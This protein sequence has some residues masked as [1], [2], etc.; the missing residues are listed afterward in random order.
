MSISKYFIDDKYLKSVLSNYI[1][2]ESQIDISDKINDAIENE[3]NLAV[4][5]PTGSG[6]TMSYLIPALSS[7]KRIIISTKTK[8]LMNQLLYR[9]IPNVQKVDFF[10]KTVRELK[11]RKNYFCPHRYFKHVNSKPAFYIDAVDWY[12]ESLKEGGAFYVPHGRLDSEVCNLMSADRYQCIGNKCNYYDE[13]PFY[14]QKKEANDADIVITNHFMLLSD[15]AMK[16]KN[17]YG[18]IF[19]FRDHIIFDEAHSISDI[20]STYAGIEINIYSIFI[21]FF[22]NKS[23]IDYTLLDDVYKTYANLASDIKEPKVIYEQ[24]E[25]KIDNLISKIS[26][27]VEAS[28]ID[29]MKEEFEK[30]LQLYNEFLLNEEGIRIIEKN[31]QKNNIVLSLKFIPFNAGSLF[32][33]GLANSNYSSVFISATL[34]S[35]GS[36]DYFFEETGLDSSSCVTYKVPNVFNFKAQGRLYVPESDYLQNKDKFYSDFVSSATG[37]VLIICNSIE[38]MD[39]IERVLRQSKIK[40]TVYKQTEVNIGTLDFSSEDMV[41][42]GSAG[43]REGIDISGG[44]FTVVILDQLPFEFHKD[45]ILQKRGEQIEKRGGNAFM[46]FLLPRA[47]LYFKQAVGR[48]I[49]HENDF[50]VWIVL[51]D[52]ILTKSYGKYF[53]DVIDNVEIIRNINEALEFIKG[54]KNG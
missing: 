35:N 45:L 39:F 3:Y 19:D 22:E 49:R 12:N 26:H 6:K 41:L 27:V 54:G 5:A 21:M 40:K 20:F 47:V 2:R 11:G 30:Y 42:I 9:D 25:E 17:S 4:E 10:D 1:V 14:I 43:L 46:D 50:G 44:G 7:N 24:F 28:D 32:L 34:S 13:C 29:D 31:I 23:D 48:L 33:E 8:Q 38:R 18:S 15:I 16:S 52:R 51:D 53:K 36:F 37:S